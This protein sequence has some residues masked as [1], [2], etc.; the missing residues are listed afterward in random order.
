M[1]PRS[2]KFVF[3]T[4]NAIASRRHDAETEL[5]LAHVIE[6]EL[7]VIKFGH[8]IEH[9]EIAPSSPYVQ[10]GLAVA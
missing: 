9:T 5:C 10:S 8:Q 2:L 7:L 3:E 6:R 4:I 1:Q